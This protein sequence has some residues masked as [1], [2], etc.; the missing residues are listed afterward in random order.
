MRFPARLDE[1]A[2]TESADAS[3][4]AA[5]DWPPVAAGQ[6][7]AAPATASSPRATRQAASTA[8]MSLDDL[9]RHEVQTGSAKHR[10]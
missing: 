3:R 8:G 7:S 10:P 6:A 2:G 5:P 4:R 1:V 9:T